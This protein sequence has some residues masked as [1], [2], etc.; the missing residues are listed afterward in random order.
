VLPHAEAKTSPIPA[1]AV[2][3]DV[4]GILL[5]HFPIKISDVIVMVAMDVKVVLTSTWPR[6][7]RMT[8]HWSASADVVLPDA[9][10]H[11]LTLGG[12][13]WDVVVGLPG[14][15]AT[16][17]HRD[18]PFP[19][20]YVTDP[21]ITFGCLHSMVQAAVFMA[22]GALEPVVV[23]GVG[24]RSD[25]ALLLATRR[26][27]VLTATECVHPVLAG[28][29]P[30]GTGGADTFMRVLTEHVAPYVED[31]YPIDPARRCV[32]GHSLGGLFVCHALLTRTDF[33]RAFLAVSPSLWWDE[34]VLLGRAA[35]LDVGALSGCEL[36]VATGEH[37]SRPNASWPPIPSPLSEAME[38]IDMVADATRFADLLGVGSGVRIRQEVIPDEHH[39]TVWPAAMMRGLVHLFKQPC[40]R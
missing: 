34:G 16:G 2:R 25:D 9:V 32:A 35:N 15:L 20:I 33:F 22:S 6:E 23:V 1:R 26:N 38:G 7:L 29:T 17:Q 36:Y 5:T 12:E 39:A 28:Q 18:G 4:V 21:A 14:G 8:G 13:D 30:Y 19:V 31:L 3:A 40:A 24:P 10:R 11:V 27:R 37:E